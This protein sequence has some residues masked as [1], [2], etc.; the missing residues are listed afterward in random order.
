[1]AKKKTVKKQASRSGGFYG[2]RCTDEDVELLEN[3]AKIEGFSTVTQWMLVNSRK[4]ARAILAAAESG[5]VKIMET[6]IIPEE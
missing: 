6:L 1:M 2:V 5:N 4:R 3:A